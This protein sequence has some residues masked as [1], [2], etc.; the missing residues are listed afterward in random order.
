M[1]CVSIHVTGQVQGVFFR[2]TAK[3]MAVELGV[4]G[5]VRNEPDGSVY[6]EVEGDDALIEKFVAW[7]QDGPEQAKVENV[8]VKR[9]PLRDFDGFQVERDR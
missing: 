3:A 4:A 9:L 7:C 8:E 2:E 6:M 1:R 5:L